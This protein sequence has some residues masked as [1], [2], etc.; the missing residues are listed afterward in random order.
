MRGSKGGLDKQ[1]RTRDYFQSGG[2]NSQ[3]GHDLLKQQNIRDTTVLA[4]T[5]ISVTE[6]NKVQDCLIALHHR[7]RQAKDLTK[8]RKE[9]S[10]PRDRHLAG[11][12]TP[13][14]APIEEPGPLDW[15]KAAVE[16]LS[17]RRTSEPQKSAAVTHKTS[18]EKAAF[19]TRR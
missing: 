11:I 14:I 18:L 17:L 6:K 12:D 16:R 7:N 9:L 10:Y 4:A 1:L 3:D 19:R 5:A 15:H 8:K 2:R 13:S